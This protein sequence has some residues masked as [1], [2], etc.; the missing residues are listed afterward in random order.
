MLIC[1]ASGVHFTTY[2]R[3]NIRPK[4]W[5]KLE[6]IERL[7]SF[8]EAKLLWSVDSLHSG[9]VMRK[10]FPLRDVMMCNWSNAFGTLKHILTSIEKAFENI[11]SEMAAI[12]FHRPQ[13]V[14]WK[15]AKCQSCILHICAN[16]AVNKPVFVQIHNGAM[17]SAG[18]VLTEKTNAFNAKVI[19]L[20]TCM[21]RFTS[22]KTADKYWRN[23]AALG[24]R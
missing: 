3:R 14:Q 22:V 15:P 13:C 16:Y 18:T 1:E 9:P 20:I 11:V 12:T 8:C 6:Q 24:F 17:P 10:A 2:C 23:I 7:C 5:F 21:E 19:W 4:F